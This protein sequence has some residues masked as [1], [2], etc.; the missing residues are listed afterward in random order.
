MNLGVHDEPSLFGRFCAR[1]RLRPSF[2]ATSLASYILEIL[3][4]LPAAVYLC[5]KED[6]GLLAICDFYFKPGG[7]DFC[8]FKLLKSAAMIMQS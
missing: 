1:L 4:I 2:P 8:S 5:L 6:I 7:L 3:L